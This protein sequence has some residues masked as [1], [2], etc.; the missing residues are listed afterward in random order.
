M[1][2][3]LAEIWDW[4]IDEIVSD[5]FLYNELEFAQMNFTK[6]TFDLI[7]L[8]MRCLRIWLENYDKDVENSFFFLFQILFQLFKILNSFECIF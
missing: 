2:N 8:Q 7:D 5:R 4:R 6:N 3:I 1:L